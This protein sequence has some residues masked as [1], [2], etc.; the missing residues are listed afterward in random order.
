[1]RETTDAGETYLGE[2]AAA[3]AMPFRSPRGRRALHPSPVGRGDL[4][5][6]LPNWVTFRNLFNGII[7]IWEVAKSLLE[8]TVIDHEHTAKSI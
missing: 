8:A 4:I 7:F 2:V 3:I 5:K 1:M 6:N